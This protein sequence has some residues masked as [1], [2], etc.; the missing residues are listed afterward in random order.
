MKSN[1]KKTEFKKRLTELTSKEKDFSLFT[2]YN[3]SGTPF[4]GTYDDKTFE[5]TRNSF[6]RHVKAIVIKGEYKEFDNNSTE[7]IYTI[8]V[9]K[10]MRNL[11]IVFACFS[12]ILFNT[13][14]IVNGDNFKEPFLSVILTINGFIIFAGLWGLTINFL[15]KR[16]VNQ[17]FK[18]EFEIGVVDEWEKLAASIT[19]G[20]SL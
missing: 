16:I 5:L 11:T 4:C 12:F 2:S 19:N 10:F 13:V 8:G 14:I 9:T 17:R 1:L 20:N 3:S 18:E 15:T 7:V 6:W